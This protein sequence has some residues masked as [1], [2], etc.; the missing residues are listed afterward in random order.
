[1]AASEA[2]A[3]QAALQTRHRG[4]LIFAV[5]GASFI[6][7][8]DA[9]IAN[10]AIPH[11]QT[12]LNA[13]QDTVTW[14]LTSFIIAGAVATPIT[15][16]LADRFGSRNLFLAAVAGFI[17]TSML[18]GTSVNLTQMV[19]FR[20]MQGICAAFIGPMSQSV[21]LDISEPQDQPRVMTIWSI[22]VILAPI[23]GPTIGGWLT[24]S[25]NWRWVFYINLPIGIPTLIIM[26]WLLPSRP[27]RPRRLD[28]FGY[29]LFAFSL[30]TFQLML[31]RGQHADWFDSW[32]IIIELLLAI[33]AFWIFLVHMITAKNPLFDRALFRDRNF[34]TAMSFMIV[35]GMVMVAISALLPPM[36]QSIYGY[37]VLDTGLLL[38]PRGIGTLLTMMMAPAL[39]RF[40]QPRWLICAGFAVITYSMNLMMG[41]TIEMDSTPIIVSGFVQGIGMGFLFMP[42]NLV[43]FATLPPHLRTDG[44]SLLNLLRN[45]G[46]SVGIS[47]ITTLLSRNIQT[48]HADLGGHITPFNIPGLDPSSAE[49]MG[50][51]GEAALQMLNLEVNRQAAMIAYLDDFKMM[52][53]MVALA[54]PL[55]LFLRSPPRQQQAALPPME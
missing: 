37:T 16:W 46:A 45:L 13:S 9:T 30:A 20:I 2:I 53:F 10:V 11:M 22:G 4:L 8:L 38:A 29:A 54:V 36:L 21:L 34:A 24:E 49:R 14:V 51:Y 3:G 33:S 32:E 41:W 18:C 19:S 26:W 40:I 47:L 7:F 23:C 39:V 31:D 12:S 15:G 25:Y 17:L 50:S 27:I 42:L 44:S 5:M 43:A 1:M 48:S 28:M 35:M 52:A 6:Q 55:S